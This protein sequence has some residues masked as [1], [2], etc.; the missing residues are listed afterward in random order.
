MQYLREH[1]C[2]SSQPFISS[3]T[4]KSLTIEKQVFWGNISTWISR[5]ERP[6]ASRHFRQW[7][8]TK[9]KNWGILCLRSQ[10]STHLYHRNVLALLCIHF[11]IS[12]AGRHLARITKMCVCGRY[13]KIVQKRLWASLA[14]ERFLCLIKSSFHTDGISSSC[15]SS[16]GLGR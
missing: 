6:R 1:T 9:W 12:R 8:R 10:P 11:C 5:W 3:S 15:T 16:W 7:R 4:L 2:T 13:A 14:K